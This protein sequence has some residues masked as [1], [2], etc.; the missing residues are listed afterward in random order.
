MMMNIFDLEERQGKTFHEGV[1]WTRLG[2]SRKGVAWDRELRA[3]QFLGYPRFQ[4]LIFH[5][6]I[7]SIVQNIWSYQ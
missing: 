1:S 5:Y 2:I 4:Q 7:Q 3:S 6:L